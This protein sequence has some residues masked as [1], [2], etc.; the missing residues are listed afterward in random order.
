V[1]Q[2]VSYSTRFDTTDLSATFETLVTEAAH[3]KRS[4]KTGQLLVTVG[5]VTVKQ[6]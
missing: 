3:E 4:T 2:G 5:A 1:E 6:I